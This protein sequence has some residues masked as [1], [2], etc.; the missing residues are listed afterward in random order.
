MGYFNFWDEYLIANTRT[1][2]KKLFWVIVNRT[3]RKF[4]KNVKDEQRKDICCELS[5]SI[6]KRKPEEMFIDFP[7]LSDVEVERISNE[8]IK[9]R[10]Y[11]QSSR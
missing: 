9:R 10:R 3:G 2:N 7:E 8:I 11:C 1:S 6:R 4:T 5:K